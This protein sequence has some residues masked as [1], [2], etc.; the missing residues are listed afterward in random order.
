MKN[1]TISDSDRESYKRLKHA[2]ARKE[3]TLIFAILFIFLASV[4]V[5]NHFGEEVGSVTFMTSLISYLF[6]YW[7]ATAIGDIRVEMVSLHRPD[8]NE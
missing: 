6:G 5:G 7:Y 1:P 4:A 3:K 8:S 2:E